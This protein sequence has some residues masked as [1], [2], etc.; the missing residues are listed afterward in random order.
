MKAAD[1]NMLVRLLTQDDPD[2]AEW[3]LRHAYGFG[4]DDVNRALTAVAELGNAVVQDEPAVR[5]ALSWHGQGLDFAD[6]LHLATASAA[7]EMITFDRKLV[8]TA[9]RIGAARV[10]LL[11]R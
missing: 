6:A 7:D 11:E 2:Q 3:V 9:S 1:T 4:R 10:R 5:R 8:S